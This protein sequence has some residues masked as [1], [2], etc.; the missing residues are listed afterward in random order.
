[1]FNLYIV[2]EDFMSEVRGVRRLASQESVSW[3]FSSPLKYK[4]EIV[5][6]VTS[7]ML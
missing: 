1:M 3:T 5:P 7:Y 2:F 6:T 4:I